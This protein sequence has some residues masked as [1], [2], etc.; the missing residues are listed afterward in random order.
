[1]SLH[2]YLLAAAVIAGL[3]RG[4]KSESFIFGM[5]EIEACLKKAPLSMNCLDEA[6]IIKKCLK[7]GYDLL[8][9]NSSYSRNKNHG[10][11]RAAHCAIDKCVKGVMER[12][13]NAEGLFSG[14]TEPIL[15]CLQSVS[16]CV[17]NNPRDEL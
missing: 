3:C 8:F 6:C 4:T 7:L 15:A 13:D 12:K 2:I 5:N 11:S 9:E 17:K 1:M 14:W 16:S 10:V